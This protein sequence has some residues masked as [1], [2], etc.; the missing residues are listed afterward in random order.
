MGLFSSIKSFLGIGS[1]SVD[2]KVVVNS[3][4][5]GNPVAQSKNY[6]LYAESLLEYSLRASKEYR[7]SFDRTIKN[8]YRT[9]VLRAL[10]KRYHDY[11]VLSYLGTLKKMRNHS[12]LT[13][14]RMYH[15]LPS[16][17]IEENYFNLQLAKLGAMLDIE[18][19]LDVKEVGLIVYEGLNRI[20]ASCDKLM[21]E[22]LHMRHDESRLGEAKRVQDIGVMIKVKLAKHGREA[23]SWQMDFERVTTL[24]VLSKS[25]RLEAAISLTARAYQDYKESLSTAKLTQP[26]VLRVVEY[27]DECNRSFVSWVA[28]YARM[29]NSM[30]RS[31][32]TTG[33][34]TPD[35]IADFSD[36]SARFVSEC[37]VRDSKLSLML[38]DLTVKSLISRKAA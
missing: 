4:H 6:V 19:N 18:K 31:L 3:S 17:I 26:A 34:Y 5:S 15:S 30:Q 8:E 23:A 22:C 1:S 29:R 16:A 24:N 2:E 38:D 9:P 35:T 25:S 20:D 10:I 21:S 14:L 13:G 27:C 12:G 37:K 32:A 28:N 7:I 11:V 36:F 33:K